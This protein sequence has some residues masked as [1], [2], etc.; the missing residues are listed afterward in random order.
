VDGLKFPKPGKMMKGYRRVEI[1][2][3]D[4]AVSLLERLHRASR[5]I[6]DSKLAR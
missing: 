1:R 4:S 2:D 5:K 3:R 6:V